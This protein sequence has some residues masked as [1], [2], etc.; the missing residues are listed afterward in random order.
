[1]RQLSVTG[2]GFS[3]AP[4]PLPSFLAAGEEAAFELRCEPQSP[5]FLQGSLQLDTRSFSIAA[6]GRAPEA[7]DAW[8]ELDTQA[9][10]S[11]RQSS[12][13]IRLAAPATMSVTGSLRLEFI[14]AVNTVRG[15]EAIQ[16]LTNSSRS[17]PVQVN[18]GDTIARV[19]GQP[20]TAFQT[21]TTAGSLVFRLSLGAQE[22]EVTV[23]LPP[24][25]PL[26]DSVEM[27]T[28][29]GSVEV[30][31]TGFDNHRTSGNV[32]F[33]FT[34]RA[35]NELP[36]VSAEAGVAF[37]AH[38][39]ES[40][41]GGLFRLTARFPVTGDPSQLARVAVRLANTIGAGAGRSE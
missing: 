35:G 31:V 40:Q 15:D 18:P 27:K 37:A 10:R 34:D 11:G 3:L 1:V 8:I 13:R 36:A 32:V 4:T 41:M 26:I 19:A 22:R 33:T 2:A 21:G 24:E 29:Q 17:V 9:A 23:A 14:P 7:P 16:F 39:R 25:A 20:E 12:V 38:F 30:A 6:L 5:G 28:G